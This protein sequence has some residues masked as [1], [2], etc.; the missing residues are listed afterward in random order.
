MESDTGFAQRVAICKSNLVYLSPGLIY[1]SLANCHSFESGANCQS[2]GYAM[3]LC[4]APESNKTVLIY[5]LQD[6]RRFKSLEESKD[7]R[8][9]SI[10]L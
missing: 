4:L 8:Y 10:P 5:S 6:I 1:K 3:K 2:C 9:S 7:R